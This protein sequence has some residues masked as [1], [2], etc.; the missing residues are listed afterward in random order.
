M[1]GCATVQKPNAHL[2][3]QTRGDLI[4]LL[5]LMVKLEKE[6]ENS[7]GHS[8]SQAIASIA[9]MIGTHHRQV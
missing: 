5:C 3:V 7:T 9:C 6:Q 1:K 8:A 4:P 2:A